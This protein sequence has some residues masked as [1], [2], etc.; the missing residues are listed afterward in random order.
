MNPTEL[1]RM[2]R[3]A[4]WLAAAGLLFSAI[5]GAAACADSD[6]PMEVAVAPTATELRSWVSQLDADDFSVR[7]AATRNL[8]EAGADAVLAAVAQ[9][10]PRV[11]AEK[12]DVTATYTNA[13]SERAAA[14]FGLPIP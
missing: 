13:F 6:E 9:V 14:K 8:S 11:T 12:V 7:E 3:L 10:N 2:P 1:S 4:I 5:G